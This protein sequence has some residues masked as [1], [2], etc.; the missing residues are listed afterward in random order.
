MN[1]TLD[2]YQQV[3]SGKKNSL[4]E[5]QMKN[6]LKSCMKC[7]KVFECKTRED[8]VNAVYESMS[9]GKTGGFEF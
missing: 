9:H 7:D 5:C 2:E 1:K 8:Y 4:K 6:G 3:L